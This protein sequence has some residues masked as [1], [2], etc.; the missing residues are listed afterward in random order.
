MLLP[1]ISSIFQR[2]LDD[3][4]DLHYILY[5]PGEIDNDR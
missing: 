5:K 4:A 1:V 3:G 2:K